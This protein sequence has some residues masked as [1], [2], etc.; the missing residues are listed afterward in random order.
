RDHRVWEMPPPT[1]GLAAAGLLRRFEQRGPEELLGVSFGSILRRERDLVYG[2][3]DRHITDPDFVTVPVEP[4]LDP[5]ALAPA[6]GDP[7]ADG[8]TIA[9]TVVD[10]EGTLVS[11]IQSE[12]GAFGSG[13]VA[14]GTGILLQNRGSYFSLDPAHVNRLEP[15]KRT[16]HTL[17]PAMAAGRGR[18]IAFGT[19]GGDGQPQLQT[20]VLLQ[21]VDG[22]RSAQEAVAAPRIRV[23]DSTTTS[24]EAD[25][26]QAREWLRS[27][28]GAKA[29]PPLDDSFGHASA[30][31]A[32]E[33]GGWDAGADPRS[34]GGVGR[35]E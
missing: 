33:D 20:Q 8:D 17:I 1:Q 34:D 27:L 6:A 23:V 24:I 21:L 2:L 25:H 15:R 5:A 14:R 9:L 12:S 32:A 30:I 13:V 29:L 19:M 10:D 35:A 18:R 28:P 16:M 11:L 26:P 4:F 31:V 3:R 22:R 7:L